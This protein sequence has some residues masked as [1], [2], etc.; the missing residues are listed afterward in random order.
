ME[1]RTLPPTPKRLRD[2]RKRGEVVR[3]AD[4]VSAGVFAGALAMLA[5]LGPWVWMASAGLWRHALESI[6]P[7]AA[8]PS[9]APMLG[10][11]AEVLWRVFAVTCGL[12]LVF[13]VA[14]AFAQVGGL[15]AWERLKP[16]IE[17]LDPSE[18]LKNLFSG[19]NLLQL[20]KVI[21]QTLLL[22]LLMAVVIRA[23]LDT[24][25]RSGHGT[26]AGVL[27]VGARLM[28]VVGAWAAVIYALM[29]VADYVIQRHEF[30]RRQRMSIQDLRDEYRETEGDPAN[31][32]RR[33]EL[34]HEVLYAGL[35]DRVRASQLVLHSAQVAVALQWPQGEVPSEG[36]GAPAPR[37][38]ARGEGEV[39]AQMR[40]NA[41]DEGVALSFDAALAERIHAEVALDNDVPPHLTAALA[42]RDSS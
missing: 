40:R 7:G 17:R 34:H 33:R 22:L 16:Q 14:A 32:S 10:H 38:L 28:F 13:S 12:A 3:S 5:L 21:V 29:A 31:V 23:A 24:A 37:V 18:G 9:L 26:P 35:R 6:G 42:H 30:M 25:I 19:H 2:A 1:E 20:G 27:T 4:V 36:D 39:A 8:G 41:R 11:G 15:M